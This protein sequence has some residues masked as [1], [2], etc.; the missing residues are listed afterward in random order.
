[1]SQTIQERIEA[2][3]IARFPTDG[4]ISRVALEQSDLPSGIR[5]F[6]LQSLDRRVHLASTGMLGKGG[7][8]I[9][10][11]HP[12]LQEV[13][14]RLSEELREAGQF[15]QADWQKAV[16]QSVDVQLAYL[17]QPA[18]ALAE[19]AFSAGSSTLPA[20]DLRRRTGYFSDY[21]YMAKAVDAW[22]AK[23]DEQHI[24]RNAFE[25]AMRHLD[26]RLTDDYS[27]QQWMQLLGPLV[28]TMQFAGVKP[29]GLPVPMVTRFFDAKERPA[30]ADLV[31]SA[32]ALHRAEMI[33]LPSLSDIIQ[34]AFENE[35]LQ[36]A[37]HNTPAAGESNPEPS[38]P[39]AANE[40]GAPK[41]SSSP[42]EPLSTEGHSPEAESSQPLPLWKRFQQRVDGPEAG[43]PASISPKDAGSQPLWKSFEKPTGSRPGAPSLSTTHEPA[44]GPE[45]RA[46]PDPVPIRQAPRLEAQ[47]I[48][49]GTAVRS[50]DRFIRDL[51]DG[52]EDMYSDV[53][54]DLAQAP[55]WTEAS[56]IIADRVFR[57]N[58][59]D[60][61]SD[62]AVD[63]T[64]AVEARYSGLQS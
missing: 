41:A 10:V 21:P 12:V 18:R 14:T 16:S 36:E 6:L 44:R 25:S 63:F 33:T 2:A 62:V 22:L 51:F 58:R 50:R 1:M 9:D 60:I 35:R 43:A 61:Y 39:I 27:E 54:E 11:N 57:P 8:W 20:S 47:H 3:L 42:V 53:M 56:S 38:Q 4:P 26:C 37:E 45:T 29:A 32:A 48:V 28:E 34:K 46:R 17:Q 23:R 40:P 30:I 13:A 52:N 24:D 19:F 55:G 5:H 7:G 59:I 49:L 15:P 31:R 64:N